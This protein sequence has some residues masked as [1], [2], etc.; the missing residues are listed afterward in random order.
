MS[1]FASTTVSYPK[2]EKRITFTEKQKILL[3]LI[4]EG[5][6]HTLAYGGSRS[7]K[8]RT[9]LEYIFRQ[10]LKYPGLRAV[11]L[12]QYV[13]HAKFSLWN[14]TIKSIIT[15]YNR[16]YPNE[17]LFK[18]NNTDLS[19]TFA[20]GSELYIGGLDDEERL[21]KILGREFAIIYL[22][23]CSQI[24]YDA[25]LICKTRLAQNING[26]KNRMFYDCN[27]P[28]PS[29]WLYKLFIQKI[30]PKSNKPLIDPDEY[31]SMQINPID[32]IENLPKD[33]LATLQSLPE[34]ERKR[35]LYGEFVKVEG[36]IYDKFDL[37][38]MSVDFNDI[39]PFEYF[40]V[41]IDNTG[42]NFAAIL[43]G[44]AG[45]KVYILGE[46]TAFRETM[47]NFD[48]DIQYSW[49]QYNYV[50]YCDPAAAQLN[51]LVWNGTN[52]DNAVAAGIEYIKGKMENNE[53][54]IVTRN[55]QAVC[56][57]L[58]SEIDLY[59]YDDKGRIIKEADHCLDAA[60]YSIYSHAKYGASI[61][62][63]IR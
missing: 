52:A 49:R 55:G 18:L 8:T 25:V 6:T 29:H 10:C 7:G 50:A 2:E 59:R 46:K 34:R 38:S 28:S 23:E 62:K 19:I 1:D 11:V 54:F 3:K 26:F 39:P 42:T 36:S 5:H 15:S 60:R 27:P 37:A 40:T 9:D 44:W 51:Q 56:P 22:N 33:Y 47:Q 13:S 61:L 63:Q 58:L 16:K 20:N 21:E 41:G 57:T 53:F 24:S 43:V 14:E 17:E 4:K 30:E 45:N 32:N 48:A 12:R 31:C 35:F